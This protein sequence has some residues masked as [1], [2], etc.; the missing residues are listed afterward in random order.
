MSHFLVTGA[1]GL[2]GLNFSLAVDGKKHQVTGVANTLPMAWA[3]F[4][5]VQAELTVPGVFERLLDEHR[6]DVV[7]HC[8]ALANIDACEADPGLA[9]R[10]NSELPGEIAA[11]CRQRDITLIHIST[12]AVFDGI[13]GNYSEEDE[14]NPVSVY[15]RTKLDGEKAVLDANDNALVARVNFYGWSA[16]G[17]RSLAE[18]FVKTLA[19]GQTMKGFTDVIFCP[20][21]I[22]DLSDLLVETTNSGLHGLYHLVGAEPM[23]KYEFGVHIARQ[24]GFDPALIEPVFVEQAG[25]KAA[26]SPNLSLSTKKITAALGHELPD[27]KEGLKKFYDQFRRGY[28]QYLRSLIES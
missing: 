12:D 25:L 3:T 17:N 23:S 11:S 9:K 22:M 27:F 14:P 5:N 8:A 19:A 16:A 20:M 10:L 1:S 24:F 6:P 18:L 4:K 15:A 13:K 28:P 2:L 21:N 7:L 26:R